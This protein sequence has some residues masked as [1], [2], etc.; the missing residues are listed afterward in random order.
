MSSQT[1]RT[2][3]ELRRIA[4]QIP[5]AFVVAALMGVS[6]PAVALAQP[7][8]EAPRNPLAGGTTEELKVEVSEHDTVD[9]HVKDE[10]LSNV[11]EL[12]SIQSER[13]IIISK[14]VSAKVTASLYNVTFYEALDAILHING[15][16]YVEQGGFIYVHTIEEL[17]AIE[18][19]AKQRV[20]KV[21]HLDY[22]TSDDAKVFVEPLLSNDGGE[23]HTSVA[24]EDFTLGD[25]APAG[26]DD[27]ALGAML[28]VYDFEENI[29]QIER[30]VQE[31]DTRPEQVLV[32][33]TI[34]QTS[35]TEMNAFG[36]DFSVI[37]DLDFMDFAGSPLG[38]V[39]RLISGSSGD[40]DNGAGGIASTPGSTATG[41]STLKLGVT[42]DHFSVFV[43]LLDEVSDTTILANPK[44]ICL[45]RQPSRVL[46]GRRVGYL[47]TTTTDTSTTQTIEF[48][49]TGTQLYFRPFVSSSNEIRME[50]K[51]QVSEAILRDTTDVNA[52]TV[53][54]PDEVTQ[55]IVTNVLVRDEQTIVLGGLFREATSL[56]RRQVPILGDI[57]IIGQAFRGNDDETTRSEIIFMITPSIVTDSLLASAT[58]S[59]NEDVE[60]IRTG[61]RRG[62]LWWSRDR[63]TAQL[64]IDAQ[65]AAR[66]GNYDEAQHLIS[67]SLSL[68][69]LQPS[70]YRLR[71]RITGEAEIWP[72][73][74]MLDAALSDELQAA[75]D[76]IEPQNGIGVSAATLRRQNAAL[77]NNPMFSD[78][79]MTDRKL[80]MFSAPGNG[81][82]MPLETNDFDASDE[83]FTNANTPE[84]LNGQEM[85]GNGSASAVEAG[86]VSLMVSDLPL[87]DVLASM[88]E[89]SG[90]TILLSDQTDVVVSASFESMPFYDALDAVLGAHAFDY[91]MSGQI[92]TVFPTFA[93]GEFVAGQIP[94]ADMARMDLM[95]NEETLLNVMDI[96]SEESGI[97]IDVPPAFASET[98]SVQ[99]VDVTFDDAMTNVLEPL[100]LAREMQADGSILIQRAAFTQVDPATDGNGSDRSI[101][102]AA[103]SVDGSAKADLS[104][105]FSPAEM[106]RIEAVQKTL[107]SLRDQIESYAATNDG[108]LPT[109]DAVFAWTDMTSTGMID[110]EPI[111]TWIGGPNASKVIAGE[112]ADRGFHTQYGWVFDN[113][114]GELW[115]AGFDSFD[116]PLDP[117]E[118]AAG[119]EGI[120]TNDPM[121]PTDLF[122][123]FVSPDNVFSK[124]KET[125]ESAGDDSVAGVETSK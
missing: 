96:L 41:P 54:I 32:Q 44:I 101:D 79:A 2:A 95:F 99:M 24:S 26:A 27:Y 64:N 68:N 104:E 117:S 110:D 74:N 22:I 40:D 15:F 107:G 9:L 10:D 63:M 91:A 6:A 98:V 13:N 121:W 18:Q 80:R 60:R 112:T 109:L 124:M 73:R 7:V 89:Q 38:A 87:A 88:S 94:G 62:V 29:N 81:S 58:E 119:T 35:L 42:G 120:G 17:I 102:G 53:T 72:N 66:D 90:Q 57:P 16:G 116:R 84:Q 65:Q 76:A 49:D 71:D 106:A 20:A 36:V 56:S 52:A 19:A 113:T 82:D 103:P 86:T 115:A 3:R 4:G 75:M 77:D 50:L 105:R 28:V 83:A 108:A 125:S 1:N 30:L 34:L 78:R 123:R 5:T 43:R 67:R 114:T 39:D 100:G 8:D 93:E 97:A 69:P 23:I 14:N 118:M 11:L 12:L 31:I 61:A 48:L 59:A 70:V 92:V 85:I 21:I 45:N 46:V 111:N 37:A 47:S 25:D 51:P 33:A 55:E 122:G